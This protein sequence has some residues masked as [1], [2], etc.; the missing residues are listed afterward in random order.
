VP[1][2]AGA[3]SRHGSGQVGGPLAVEG[4]PSPYGNFPGKDGMI[5]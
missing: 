1:S 4:V 3:G 5:L 2:G